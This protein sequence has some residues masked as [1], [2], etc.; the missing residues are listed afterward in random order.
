MSRLDHRKAYLDTAKAGLDNRYARINA[1]IAAFRAQ[2]AVLLKQRGAIERRME[3]I[4]AEMRRNFAAWEAKSAELRAMQA[5]IDRINTLCGIADRR[6]AQNERDGCEALKHCHSVNWDGA[7]TNLRPL[8]P[9]E[10]GPLA[11]PNR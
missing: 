10:R 2:E 1:D 11:T 9:L 8:G 3:E 6:C 4:A 7:R 5:R